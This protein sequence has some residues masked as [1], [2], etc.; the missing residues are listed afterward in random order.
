[1]IYHECHELHCLYKYIVLSIIHFHT[2]INIF[3]FRFII[4]S[5]GRTTVLG[6]THGNQKPMSIARNWYSNLKAVVWKWFWVSKIIF[7]L[8]IFS[9]VWI[10]KCVS[11]CEIVVFI[12]RSK[13][14]YRWR[15]HV[16]G[17]I[18]KERIVWRKNITTG[19]TILAT[20]TG[21]FSTKSG[22]LEFFGTCISRWKS[23]RW[24]GKSNW[25]SITHNM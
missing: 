16:F 4:F 9:K 17:E 22:L 5:S 15:I 10:C 21:E 3:C 25:C 18:E 23:N 8:E 12:P 2:Y 24:N 14:Q 13:H 20:L 7:F 1:M 11:I 6:T 19:Q